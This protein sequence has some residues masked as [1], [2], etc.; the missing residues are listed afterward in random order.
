MHSGIRFDSFVPYYDYINAL[1][2]S[3]SFKKLLIFWR[4]SGSPLNKEDW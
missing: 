4:N 2:V 3:R 1:F